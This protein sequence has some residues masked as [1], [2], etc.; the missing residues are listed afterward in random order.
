MYLPDASDSRPRESLA[1]QYRAGPK[2]WR[3]FWT[4]GT[5]GFIILKPSMRPDLPTGTV[6][7]LF[8]DVEGSTRLLEE[9]GGPTGYSSSESLE[10]T[11]R[12]GAP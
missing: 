11:R 5:C 9:I 4:C 1:A 2:R 8:T 10:A 3:T 6:T 7:F 12:S